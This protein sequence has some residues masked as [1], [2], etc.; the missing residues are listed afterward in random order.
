M[1]EDD[2]STAKVLSVTQM[3]VKD[4]IQFV[5]LNGMVMCAA[6]Q[7][8]H[9]PHE[10][11]VCAVAYGD[12]IDEKALAGGLKGRLGRTFGIVQVRH[13]EGIVRDAIQGGLQGA[14]LQPV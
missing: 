2:L 8:G 1:R 6:C 13:G 9:H 5:G 11:L 12:G 14:P 7:F 4:G 3:S 10:I